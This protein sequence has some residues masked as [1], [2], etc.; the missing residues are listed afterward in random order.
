MDLVWFGFLGSLKII[1]VR[2]KARIGGRK[3][4]RTAVVDCLWRMGFVSDMMV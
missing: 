2:M 1:Y 4:G 3:E